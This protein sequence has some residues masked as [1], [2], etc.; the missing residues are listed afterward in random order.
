MK[1]YQNGITLILNDEM[2]FETVLKEI[3]DKFAESRFFFKDA[4]V[5]LSIEGRNLTKEE[6]IDILEEIQNNSD[7]QVICIVG[8][9][10]ETDRLYLRATKQVERKFRGGSEGQFYK[11]S[12]RNREVLEART[13]IIVLGDVTAGCKVVSTGNI[14]ILGCLYGEAYAGAAG[15]EDHYVVALEM[16]PEKIKIGDFKYDSASKQKSR[17]KSPELQP[18][19]AYVNDERIV[20]N[21]LTKDLPVGFR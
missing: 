15:N 5:A 2:P 21:P 11:G 17:G 8:K 19:I 13:S 20:F 14:I 7:I 10:E 18:K 4:K 16:K 12:L 6:E 1:S 3:G 9:D